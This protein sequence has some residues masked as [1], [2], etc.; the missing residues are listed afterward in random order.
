MQRLGS[1]L[2]RAR[3]AM[4][5]VDS[6]ERSLAHRRQPTAQWRI[7]VQHHDGVFHVVA[8][9]LA[10]GCGASQ[11]ECAVVYCPPFQPNSDIRKEGIISK[12]EPVNIQVWLGDLHIKRECQVRGRHTVAQTW[13]LV[14]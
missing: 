9:A 3:P 5:V 1:V 4:A 10:L 14:S 11:H 8:L 12:A 13:S 7:V 2:G 6:V